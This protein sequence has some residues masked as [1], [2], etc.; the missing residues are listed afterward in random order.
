MD[1]T[2]HMSR[3][4]DLAVAAIRGADPARF[5]DP[6]PCTDYTVGTL[7]HHLAFGLLLARL[8]A[9]RRD[10]DPGVTDHEHAP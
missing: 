6:T 10:L 3:S 5:G 2:D 7:L 4:I 1:Q 8:G 9:E